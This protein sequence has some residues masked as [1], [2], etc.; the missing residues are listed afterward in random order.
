MHRS[1]FFLGGAPAARSSRPCSVA[2]GANELSAS[3]RGR[4]LP[5]GQI[6]LVTFFASRRGPANQAVAR[7]KLHASGSAR[8]SPAIEASKSGTKSRCDFPS[9]LLWCRKHN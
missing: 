3:Q 2:G 6:L 8:S 5:E 1:F 4:D 9:R 7:T